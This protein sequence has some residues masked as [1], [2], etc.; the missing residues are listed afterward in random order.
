MD[1]TSAAFGA[2]AELVLDTTEETHRRP[3][4]AIHGERRIVHTA[5]DKV[6]VFLQIPWKSSLF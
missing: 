4:L 1:S 2:L 5:E 3:L 6:Q